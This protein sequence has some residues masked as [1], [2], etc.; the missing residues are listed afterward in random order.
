MEETHSWQILPLWALGS[1]FLR[2]VSAVFLPPSSSTGR[3]QNNTGKKESSHGTGISTC[4]A[5]LESG[6]WELLSTLIAGKI[7]L[8]NLER[9]E[10]ADS[11][12]H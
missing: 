10:L 4:P 12:P 3:A 1:A 7:I 2:G 8:Y 9:Q 6:S 11:H 5:I